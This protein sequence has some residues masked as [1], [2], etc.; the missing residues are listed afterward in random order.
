MAGPFSV[1][2]LA[3]RLA[4]E[5]EGD[6]S[7]L[8]DDVCGLEDA[9]PEHLSFLSNRK[10]VRLL[11][12]SRA[13]AVLVDRDTDPRGHTVIRCDDPY[14][15]FARALAVFHPPAWPE[16]GV[17]ERSWVAADVDLE[18]VTVEAFAWIG[19]GARIG[20]GSWIQAG[21]YVGRDAR[22]GRDCRLMP[23]SV[24]CEGCVVGDR[25]WL[26][27]G[28]VVG[29]EGFGFAPSSE[30][31]VKIP[32]VGRAVVEDDVEI[33]SNS[34]VD[35]ATMGDTVVGRGTKMDNLVQIAHGVRVGEHCLLAA[36]VGIA[37]STRLG[38]GVIMA[39]KSGVANHL[40]IGD[41]VV[42]A[43]VSGVLADQPAGARVA[44]MP[45]IDHRRWLRA[46]VAFADLPD[47]VRRVQ[48]LERRFGDN[49][50]PLPIG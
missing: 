19:P 18:E 25:V 40:S 45:A 8:L 46:A 47:L 29:G 13:G 10:Y 22:V 39:A 7:R 41:G 2:E 38:R 3:D 27:P 42:A 15:A 5:V 12:S 16:P 14:V 28:A 37:G 50:E 4:G 43:A 32:Q 34:C 31:H 49:D 17:D 24:V 9:G 36:Y 26:N 11:A 35:R 20:T 48:R 30:G 33:G 1:A 21:A 6:G 23:H 44:G